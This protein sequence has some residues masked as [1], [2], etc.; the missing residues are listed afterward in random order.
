MVS[1][2]QDESMKKQ[3]ETVQYYWHRES[4]RFVNKRSGEDIC[5]V[6][7]G[8]TVGPQFHGDVKEWEMTLVETLID[9]RNALHKEAGN[10]PDSVIVHADPEVF[11]MLKSNI[12]FHPVQLHKGNLAGMEIREDRKVNYLQPIVEIKFTS[13]G[14]KQ[15]LKGSVHILEG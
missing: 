6:V 13:G 3:E 2:K 15:S 9:V 5:V 4:G 11:S 12:L 10:N 1:R 14:R 7:N 8:E